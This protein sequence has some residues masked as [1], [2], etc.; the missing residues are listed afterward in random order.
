MPSGISTILSE[1][2]TCSTHRYASPTAKGQGLVGTCCHQERDDKS[3]KV[4]MF[5]RVR[6]G[7]V[8]GRKISELSTVTGGDSSRGRR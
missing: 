8:E 3:G 2:V 7:G 5:T 6:D 4:E 1:T